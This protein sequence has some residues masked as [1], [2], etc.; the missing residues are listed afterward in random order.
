[1]R[2]FDGGVLPVLLYGCKT[3]ALKKGKL[4]RLEAFQN[5]CLCRILRSIWY[6]FMSYNELRARTVCLQLSLRIP[7][8]RLRYV[9]H[10]LR[11]SRVNV[12]TL[13]ELETNPGMRSVG[14]PSSSLI[15]LLEDVKSLLGE[16]YDQVGAVQKGWRHLLSLFRSDS[17]QAD[18]R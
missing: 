8:L 15:H 11:I 3:W 6:D 1:M 4:D 12:Q 18:S 17:E 16:D 2:I 9:G 13:A 5:S 14:R 10:V 7:L